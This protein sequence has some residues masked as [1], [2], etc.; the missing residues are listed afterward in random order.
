MK[1]VVVFGT[2]KCAQD[3]LDGI[4][5]PMQILA[6][7]DN[8]VTKVGTIEQ[9]YGKYEIVQPS[10]LRDMEF[11]YVYICSSYWYEI[12]NQLYDMGIDIYRMVFPYIT[13]FKKFVSFWF[14]KSGEK[15]RA[16]SSE[17]EMFSQILN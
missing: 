5:E 7:V 9:I 12:A 17:K 6:F 14:E 11:D 2:G 10:M 13:D 8:D 1:K 3:V 15:E 4:V 16:D